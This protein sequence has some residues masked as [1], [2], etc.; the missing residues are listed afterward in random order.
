[1]L[2]LM[3]TVNWEILGAD[4]AQSFVHVNFTQCYKRIVMLL[5]IT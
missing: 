3:V 4:Y 1:M 2:R 5:M